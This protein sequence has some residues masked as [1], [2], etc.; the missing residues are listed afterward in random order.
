M[1]LARRAV[2]GLISPTAS[3]DAYG[4]LS[5]L[6]PAAGP[7]P[8]RG[9]KELLDGYSTMPWLRAVSH[10]VASAV[11]ST[12][13]ELY[14]PAR[15]KRARTFQRAVGPSRLALFKGA[16]RDGDLVEIENH[17]LLDALDNAN[18]YLVGHSLFLLTQIHLDLGGESFWIKERNGLGVPVGFWPVPPHW[19]T[20]TPTPRR[21]VFTVKWAA[22]QGDIPATEIVWFNDPN[23]SNP[24]GRGSALAGALGD[25]LETDEY[26][27]RHTKMVFLNRAR[28]DM[29]IWPESTKF[30]G[31]E[32]SDTNARR[33]G[34]QWRAEHQGFWK[35]ALPFFS[36]RKLGVHELSQNMRDLQV[37]EL[38]KHERDMI[39]QVWG[40]PPEELGITESS[41][42]ATSEVAEHLFKKNVVVPRLE[43]IRAN[44]QERLVPDYD[45][46]LII[47]YVS[48]V[49]AD[50][51]HEL[52]VATAAPWSL[53]VD[54]WRELSGHEPLPN[55]EG[56]VFMIDLRQQPRPDLAYEPPNLTPTG[57]ATAFDTPVDE[58][59]GKGR[60]DAEIDRAFTAC[61]DAGD[62]AGQEAFRKAL[63]D[64][65]DDLPELS[66]RWAR[67][68]PAVR[69][70]IEA[71]LTGLRAETTIA[72][73]TRLLTGSLSDSAVLGAVPI[74]AWAAD[75]EVDAREWLAETFL[76]GAKVGAEQA[77]LPTRAPHPVFNV[78]NPEAVSWAHLHAGE[79]MVD[80]SLATV[81]GVRAAV[82]TGLELGWAPAKLARL[83]RE[84]VGLTDRQATSVVRFA[85]RLAKDG[86]LSD[87]ALFARTERYASAQR[88]LRSIT[89]ART[90]LAN[91]ASAGQQRL[92]DVGVK[93]GAI[94]KE[95]M[96][97]T[98]IV[99][100]DESLEARCEALGHETVSIDGEFSNGKQGPPDHPNC[101]CATGLQRKTASRSVE[102]PELRLREIVGA[103]IAPLHDAVSNLI[104]TTRRV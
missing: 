16:K 28:P 56:K 90:E 93:E 24:Y 55:D 15:S 54:E 70:E 58:G 76:V 101:R 92:W 66:R 18:S 91:A 74:K 77:G 73:L 84:T 82:A 2:T 6:Y 38:R 10:K 78:V 49:Q 29:I 14:A 5:G 89:I 87:D 52:K 36:T 17:I 12:K 21:P 95:K 11:A 32:I 4:L 59:K 64:D 62:V 69:K 13:W 79:M 45:E 60:Y 71:S 7:L 80:V 39:V 103:A 57:Q 96:V 68:E 1:Q 72:D 20:A 75:A 98:W 47:D 51:E 46:N 99:T 3:T 19:V 61:V 63:T 33:L 53:R 22:W 81:A 9:T 85:E 23:P 34:E 100:L 83:I 88:R 25:E 35:A 30:D 42:R 43:L 104:D 67:K 97:K 40:V 8:Q 50:R 65:P 31:G 48:P 86:A 102:R 26:A 44:L 27:A 94:S 37:T 41:N